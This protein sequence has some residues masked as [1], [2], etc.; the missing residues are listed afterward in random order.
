MRLSLSDFL[1]ELFDEIPNMLGGVDDSGPEPSEGEFDEL[2]DPLSDD[3]EDDW[4]E[5]ELAENSEEVEGKSDV[6]ELWHLLWLKLNLGSGE[7]E[8][9]FV[10]ILMS[11]ES[12]LFL[13][14]P[15][16]TSMVFSVVNDVLR[17]FSSF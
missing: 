4:D 7:F 15:E 16:F 10:K 1:S 9:L 3:D 14:D 5:E 11:I 12:F 13:D 8:L 17:V 2:L 6:G